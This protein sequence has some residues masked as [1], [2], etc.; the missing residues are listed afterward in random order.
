MTG[1]GTR[2]GLSFY[3]LAAFFG[4][5]VLFLYGPIATITILSFQGPEGGLTF[6]MNGV[7]LHWFRN[8]FEQQAVGDF[9]GSFR[10]S[11]ALGL[12]VMVLTVLFSLLAGFAFRRR[13]LGSGALFYLAVASL[14]VPSILVSL[15]IGLLFNILGIEPTWYGSALGAHLTWTLPFGLLIVFA[16][17][18]RFN[19][20][21]EEA[22]RDLGATPWQTVRHV[23][24]PILLPS[25][26]G[27]GL[28]GFTLSYDEFARTLMTAGSFNTLPLEIYGMTTNVTTPVL[29]A[30][31][32]L[33]TLFSFTVIGLFLAGVMIL[34]RRR[35]R[36]T[37]A[38]A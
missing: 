25:L 24:L 36:R 18:N 33:T 15:G 3:L 28:F 16:I 29:Y 5:F 9:G 35:L 7:S 19:P 17:F 30:L 1:T 4:L 32:T 38:A 12:T 31:G 10:R 13:F 22:A 2:R 8:L 21:Y 34:R 6:P 37:G 20:A 23:V 26:I 14:I 27:V 11:I